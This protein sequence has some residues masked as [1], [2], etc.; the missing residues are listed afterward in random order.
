MSEFVAGHPRL[1]KANAPLPVTAAGL[2]NVRTGRACYRLLSVSQGLFH[3]SSESGEILHVLPCC[4]PDLVTGRTIVGHYRCVVA[5]YVGFSPPFNRLDRSVL[6]IGCL[7]RL[8]L[9]PPDLVRHC[10]ELLT[11]GTANNAWTKPAL[12]S[13]CSS[14]F[15]SLSW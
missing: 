1:L 14:A 2:G 10:L 4:R 5:V 3:P 8:T 7:S 15:S 9:S 12:P 11:F 13:W 6:V